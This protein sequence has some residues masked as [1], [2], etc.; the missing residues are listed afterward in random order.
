MAVSSVAAGIKGRPSPY[1]GRML[2]PYT[3]PYP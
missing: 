1:L 2:A 3:T